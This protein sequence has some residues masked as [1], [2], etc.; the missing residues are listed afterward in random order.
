M[1]NLELLAPAGN[2]DSLRAAVVNGAN[3]VY[4]GLDKYSARAKASN[5]G[6]DDFGCA[7]DFAHLYGVRVY[8]AVNTLIKD[9]EFVD[10]LN[11]AKAAYGAGADAFIVQDLGFLIAL[12]KALPLAEI[13]ASTQ[14]GVHNKEGAK[15][16][17]ELGVKRVILS[18]ET[19]IE[20]IRDIR[21][22]TALEIEFFVHGALCVSFSGNCYFSGLISGNSGNRGQ[23]LQFCRKRY[24]LDCGEIRKSGYMLSAK[25]LMLLEDLD[26]L[27]KAGVTSFKIEGRMRR[28]SYVGESVRVYRRAL[29]CLCDNKP[30][31]EIK[32]DIKR[33]KA[34]FNR[35]DYCKA[36]L[37][38]H[39]SDV[40][41]PYINGHMG[42]KIGSVEQ[43]F[44][45]RATLRTDK[46]LRSGDGM[47][48]VRNKT[49]VGSASVA[50]VGNVMGFS[51]NVKKGDDV[52][53]TTDSALVNEIE[54][55]KKYLSVNATA[56]FK[57]GDTAKLKLSYNGEEICVE[58]ENKVEKAVSAPIDADRIEDIITAQS[59][60]VFEVKLKKAYIDENIFIPISSVKTLKRK[61]M[62]ELKARILN[63]FNRIEQKNN[64]MQDIVV[65][66]PKFSY[67][68][69]K[70][71]Q[72]FVQVESIRAVEL[73]KNYDKFIDYYVLN[74]A[75]YDIKTA[76]E[77]YNRFGER[78]VLNLPN[79]ARG[80]DI[81][82]LRN[83][84][85]ES[86]INNF[87][88]NNIYAL[89]ICKGKNV[90]C[91]FMMNLINDSFGGDKI[92]SPERG[93]FD[94]KSVN[95]IFGKMPV[96]TF[97]HCEKKNITAQGCNN[98]KGYNAMLKDE[99]GNE[100]NIR[101]HKI[102]Y[103]YFSLLNSVPIFLA[104]KA[105]ENGVEKTFIDFVG[106]SEN[107]IPKYAK[108]VFNGEKA[109]FAFTRGY[110][111]K[112]LK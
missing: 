8:V 19:L 46:N 24:T 91:G 23:C 80:G 58:S 50:T 63:N 69:E 102:R 112:K 97:C 16:L 90:L 75:E 44:G 77:F 64:T 2:F 55:R 51:G 25:D 3:A 108:K 26:K 1:S 17:E 43:V 70:K 14:M 54:S 57:S 10:A 31:N 89:E 42:L 111:N 56:V 33:L 4:L 13:H 110:F 109:D 66:F 83:I 104:D 98:C 9:S 59:D 74:P 35:G 101:R 30:N 78:A 82:V 65:N 76:N 12:R 53:L 41:Y 96:M 28:P 34:M 92:A 99:Q 32:C 71:N 88:A 67:I 106:F 39:T 49:E 38:E 48:F 84:V 87:I 29:D 86:G 60:D 85:G 22:S 45:G 6:G 52:F 73:L 36:H 5:F 107:E 103:C 40:I 7:V 61:A 11:A 47:K 20:D 37:F 95:Y 18:R 100:F 79:V 21:N 93:N 81:S 27:I 94:N 72:T 105:R 15:V 68:S 62:S